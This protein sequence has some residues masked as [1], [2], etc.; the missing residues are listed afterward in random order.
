MNSYKIPF[1]RPYLMGKELFY[2][3]QSVLSGHTSGDGMFT[4]K[5]HALMEDKFKAKKVLLTHS[6]TAALEMS[7]LL[8]DIETGDE[9][10]LPSFTF[11]STANAFYLRNAKLVF[12][13]IE[14]DTLNIN[15]HNIADAIT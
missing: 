1:N 5:C 14:P 15:V 2:I 12:V 3:A 10:M 13:D 11:V 7:A 9:V 8:C 4:K 6:C